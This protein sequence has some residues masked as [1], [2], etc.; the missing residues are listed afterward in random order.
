[1]LEQLAKKCDILVLLGNL[2]RTD[3][4]AITG[5]NPEID[6][7]I[8]ARRAQQ[9]PSQRPPERRAVVFY[10][11]IDLYKNV[12]VM[13]IDLDEAGHPASGDIDAEL[14]T[15]SKYADDAKLKVEIAKIKA[16]V[17]SQMRDAILSKRTEERQ[18]TNTQ[19]TTDSQTRLEPAA[20]VEFAGAASCRNCHQEIYDKWAKGPHA[21][22]FESLRKEEAEN[23]YDCLPCHTTGYGSSSGFITIERTPDFVG[24]QCESCHGMGSGHVGTP[25]V[26]PSGNPKNVC[27]SC[28][29]DRRSPDFDQK[30]YMEGIKHWRDD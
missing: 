14:L 11:G 24:V 26:R 7:V 17:N 3:I 30:T 4:D 2:S 28:H 21:L 25:D 5:D 16:D 13:H 1:V 18:T 27:I 19:E 8:C 22:A 12:G 15:A 29:N 9:A 6:A 10:G 20:P 23:D